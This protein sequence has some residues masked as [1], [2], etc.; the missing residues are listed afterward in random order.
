MFLRSRSRVASGGHTFCPE[1]DVP[2]PRRVKGEAGALSLSGAQCSIAVSR[3]S[4]SAGRSR[5]T[6]QLVA[7][8]AV[9][10]LSRAAPAAG[11]VCAAAHT[12]CPRCDPV[13]S[14]LLLQLCYARLHEHC[15]PD[16]VHGPAPVRRGEWPAARRSDAGIALGS[17]RSCPAR[18]MALCTASIDSARRQLASSRRVIIKMALSVSSVPEESFP[19]RLRRPYFLPGDGCTATAPG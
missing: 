10:Q 9:L 19:G 11:R 7:P 17:A 8:F 15:A 12:S 1:T 16:A 4:R 18:A 14:R 3:E 5:S 2:P 6:G 13:H